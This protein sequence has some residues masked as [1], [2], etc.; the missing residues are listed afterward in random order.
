MKLALLLLV[1]YVAA[2]LRNVI[3]DRTCPAACRTDDCITLCIR[4][5]NAP[6]KLFAGR[7]YLAT[8]LEFELEAG[9]ITSSDSCSKLGRNITYFTTLDGRL[10]AWNADTRELQQMYSV[11]GLE[12]GNGK[13]LYAVTLNRNFNTNSLLYLHYAEPIKPGDEKIVY[14]SNGT[15]P[16]P[17][18]HYTTIA[19]FKLEYGQLQP[20]AERPILRRH[21]QFSHKRSGG[22]LKSSIRNPLMPSNTS[23]L[24]Y[25]LGGDEEHAL[26]APQNNHHLS[27]IHTFVP[28]ES[29][30]REMMWA[31]GIR[32]PIDCATSMLKSD[33][34]YCLLATTPTVRTLYQ[35]KRNVNYGS[36]QYRQL[37]KDRLCEGSR[38]P[39]TGL[40]GLLNYTSGCPVS[41]IFLYTGA[42][43]RRFKAHLFLSRDAC[44]SEGSFHTTQLLHLAYNTVNGVWTTIPITTQ[45]NDDLL[46]NTKIMGGDLHSDWFIAGSSLRTGRV[47]VQR[48]KPMRASE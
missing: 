19:Q 20:L 46:V 38:V 4:Q 43:M 29:G 9:E 23:T 26:L 37:C 18:K 45:F 10:M 11:P 48:I 39:V 6:S 35:L 47:S 7:P 8:E 21:A 14:M 42:E 44:F 16:I 36:P 12:Q 2:E 41:S 15:E 28:E 33:Y 30:G 34:L 3:C 5:C 22:W 13:G 24:I 32:N 1:G 40:N 27:M 25:A 31:S 17:V